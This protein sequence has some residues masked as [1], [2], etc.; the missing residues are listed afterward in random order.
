LPK[1][2]GHLSGLGQ[3]NAL[4]RINISFTT[5]GKCSIKKPLWG[6]VIKVGERDNS[7]MITLFLSSQINK[8]FSILYTKHRDK[9]T[10]LSNSLLRG[11]T[12]GTPERVQVLQ[13]RRL[14]AL[15]RIAM[16][17]KKKDSKKAILE[18]ERSAIIEARNKGYSWETI[19]KYIGKQHGIKISRETVRKMVYSYD[20]TQASSPEKS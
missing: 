12:P 6:R 19:A 5:T 1:Q 2:D 14:G 20:L 18:K 17:R 8:I 13:D 9:K 10:P 15:D 11:V 7:T 4:P 16:G 3:G